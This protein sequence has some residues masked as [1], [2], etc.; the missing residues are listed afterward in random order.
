MV[1]N[2]LVPEINSKPK[3]SKDAVISILMTE[4]PLSLKQIYYRIKKQYGYSN[5]YQS[6]YKAVKELIEKDVLKE[7]S[8]GYEINIDWI[9]KVQSF[10]DIVETNYYAQKRFQDI[11]G[12]KESRHAKD[13]IILSF[14]S[15]FD[16]EKY[17][18]YFIKTELMK[19]RNK[20]I[21]YQIK[22]EWRPLFY[23]RAEYNYFK[24]LMKQGHKF[25]FLY[26]N[27][28]PL[29]EIAKKFYKYIGVKLKTGKQEIVTDTIILEDYFIQIFVPES[30]RVK[31]RKCLEKKDTMKLLEILNK[32][33]ESS[34][35]VIINKDN[36]LAKELKKKLLKNFK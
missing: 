12:V 22:D 23:L 34:I 33:K 3:N 6:V 14:N 31:I 20:N 17:L 5:S 9:K 4:W 10:T 19:K 24:K 27:D 18:Y 15:L 35:K 11:S 28:S 21:C 29:E 16:A 36:S 7:K 25:Y 30:L 13:L 32:P 2:I 1:F 26:E 8:E